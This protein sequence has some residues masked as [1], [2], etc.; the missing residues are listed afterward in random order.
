MK[1]AVVIP[2][3]NAAALLDT[4]IRA[5][6][7]QT[8]PADELLIV[9]A[10]SADATE[11]VATTF[12][13]GNVRVLQN[14]SGDRGSAINRALDSTDADLLAMVDAQAWLAP[15]YLKAAER[16]LADAEVALV[17]GPMR[18]RGRGAIGEAMA[19]A[20]GSPFGVGD[21]QFHFF[22]GN[23]RD[24]ESVYLGVY[25]RSAFDRVGNYNP[26]LLRTEDDDLNAR[27]RAAGMRIRLD[28]AIRSVYQCRESLG[29][30]WQQYYGYGFW[31]VA[32]ATI[33]P[34]AIR[35]RH[36][37]PA[38]FVV[39]A[40]ASG[41][42]SLVW[43]WP[44][45]PTVLIGYLAVAWVAAALDRGQSLRGRAFFPLVTLTMHLAYGIGTLRGILAWSRLKAQVRRGALESADR[46]RM[47]TPRGRDTP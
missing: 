11:E 34:E 43:W 33:R 19:A 14:P 45:L 17:G 24:V 42:V 15:D 30:I 37:I 26:A 32:L 5:V 13:Q 40:A 35:P 8:R 29:A 23:A 41:V 6:L 44:A 20:L 9:V 1:L 46:A 25:R 21:S 10:P 7:D 12:A 27:I 4:C 2:A 39:A 38:L 28:P 31:K 18:P 36:V 16:G 22:R 3:R 47:S